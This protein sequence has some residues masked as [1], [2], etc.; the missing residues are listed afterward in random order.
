MKNFQVVG[1]DIMTAAAVWSQ[2]F[3]HWSY[4]PVLSVPCSWQI[5]TLIDD[6]AFLLDGVSGKGNVLSGRPTNRLVLYKKEFCPSEVLAFNEFDRLL[7]H[8]CSI[9]SSYVCWG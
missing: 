5:I 1:K 3:L 6:F 9:P 7:I 8:E 2:F 4:K